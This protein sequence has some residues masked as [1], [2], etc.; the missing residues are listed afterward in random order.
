MPNEPSGVQK[1]QQKFTLLSLT[2]MSLPCLVGVTRMLKVSPHFKV[3][4]KSRIRG[5][6]RS[7]GAILWFFVIQW[8]LYYIIKNERKCVNSIFILKSQMFSSFMIPR[9]SPIMNTPSLLVQAGYKLLLAIQTL[10]PRDILGISNLHKSCFP[11]VSLHIIYFEPEQ[12]FSREKVI[13][14]NNN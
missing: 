9:I 11:E 6:H 12:Q 10:L 5:A 13:C 14:S 2:V 3:H 7:E 1:L 4:M 8:L